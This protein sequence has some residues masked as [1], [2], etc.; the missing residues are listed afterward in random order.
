[1]LTEVTGVTADGIGGTVMAEPPQVAILRLRPM[2]R[3]AAVKRILSP[4]TLIFWNV[5]TAPCHAAR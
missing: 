3:L 2:Y 1:M 4:N 5:S